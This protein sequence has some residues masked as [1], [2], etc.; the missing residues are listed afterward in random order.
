[1]I[2]YPN[3]LDN[4]VT[5][6]RI[7][8]NL[9]ELG[10]SAINQLREAVFS[11]EKTLGLNPQG[12]KSSVND[13]ISV[14]IGPD[15]NPKAE[16][17]QAIGLV[18]LPITNNQVANNA[19]IKEV[20]LDLNFSTASLHSNVVSLQS[21]VDIAQALLAEEN[22]NFLTHI[23][24]GLLLLDNL[25]SARHVASHI[26]IN[27]IPTDSRDTYTWDGLRD[28]DH[29]LRP[30]TQVAEALLEINNELVG[31]ENATIALVH[32]ATAISVDTS[33][34]TQL[35]AYLTN[36]QE[37]LGFVDNQETLSSGVDRSTMNANGIPRTARIQNL[38]R[39]GYTINVVPPT[40]I[41]AY[42]AEPSKIA[43]HDNINNGDDV[44]KFLPD[45]TN[46][47]FDSLF[48]NV[49][50]GDILRLN[51][52]NGIE[53]SY[54]IMSIRFLSGS[55]WSVRV[56]ANN[57]FDTGD[58]Y[59]GYARIDRPNFD[60]NTCGVLAAAGVVPSIYSSQ[61][62][63]D[64]IILGSP[65]GATAV[66]IGFD[67]GVINALHYNLYLRL[68][69]TGN[70]DV[71]YD[72]PAIDVSGNQGVTP[73]Y[74]NLDIVVENT[75][76][77][78]RLSGYNYRFIAFAHKG[79]FGIMLA[80]DYNGS[81]FSIISG[82]INYI[83][84]NIEQGSYVNNI[85]GDTTDQ[86]DALGLGFSRSGFATP[87]MSRLG[88]SEPYPTTIS[89]SN[90]S[91]LIITPVSGRNVIINGNR[92]DSLA[93][94]RFT[95]G[96]GYWSAIVTNITADI[97]HNTNFVTYSIPFDLATEDLAPGKTIVV[98][99]DTP[100]DTTI[101][102]YGRFIIDSV[103]FSCTGA[104]QTNITV[105]NSIHGTANPAQAPLPLQSRVRVY[106]SDDSVMF[107]IG[108]MVG[109]EL[110]DPTDYHHYH[111]VFVNDIGKSVAVERARMA[112]TDSGPVPGSGNIGSLSWRIRR[113]SPKLTGE[114]VGVTDFRNFIKL[115]IAGWNATTGEFNLYLVSL[116]GFT[117]GPAAKAK[118]NHVV[119]VYDKSGVNFIDIEFR[120]TYGN[121][122]TMP[123]GTV[124]IELF[125]TLK[126][127]DEYF[128]VAGVSHDGFVFKSITDL[129]DFGTISE[130]NLGDSAIKFIESG[131]R[132]L[133]ANGIIRGFKFISTENYRL[134]FK[135]GLALVNGSFVPMDATSVG[136]PTTNGE[137]FICVTDT[138]QLISIRKDNG[139][140][141]LNFIEAL[142]FKEIVDNRKDLTII[143]KATVSGGVVSP[144]DARR[145]VV[146]Q[147]LGINS[148]AYSDANS[149]SGYDDGN[150]SNV[151]FITPEALMNW[152]NEYHIKEVKV[153][154]VI[155][156]YGLTL[157][158]TSPVKLIGGSYVI[159]EARGLAFTSGNWT[160]DDADITYTPVHHLYADAND[161]FCTGGNWGGI[162][163]D[164]IP[165]SA[166]ISDFGIENSRFYSTS[167]QRAP[168][169]AIYSATGNSY[170]LF[171]NGRFVNNTFTD[172]QADRALC[173]AFV[174][175]NTPDVSMSSPYFQD[176]LVSDTKI[177]GR[178]GILI[179][180]RAT[181][182]VEYS[183]YTAMNKVLIENF[184]I[185][186]NRF[187]LIG[188]NV[189]NWIGSTEAGRFVIDNNKAELIY[190]GFS[191]TMNPFDNKY[192]YGVN[193]STGNTVSF[194]VRDNDCYYLKIEASAGANLLKSSV[195][196]NTIKRWDDV[197]YDAFVPDASEARRALVVFS[198]GLYPANITIANNTIDG[199]DGLTSGYIH[200]IY[201][202]GPGLSITG[203]I[204][205]NIAGVD[206]NSTPNGSGNGGW[207]IW[208]YGGESSTIVGNT[209][210]K[211]DGVGIA[212][213]IYSDA[214]AAIYGNTFSHFNL[215]SWSGSPDPDG[216]G[217][218]SNAN[219]NGI[220]GRGSK[221]AAWNV[222]QVVKTVPNMA[223]GIPLFHLDPG[224][225]TAITNTENNERLLYGSPA[226]S[227]NKGLKSVRFF[228][229]RGW[230]WEWNGGGLSTN[231]GTI[232]LILPLSSVIPDRA[233]LLSVEIHVY[234]SGPWDVL[235][236]DSDPI[237][238]FPQVSLELNGN[239]VDSKNP[240]TDPGGPFYTDV[241]LI[242][243]SDAL[244]TGF[245]GTRP[246]APLVKE[247]VVKMKQGL[248]GGTP[249]FGRWLGPTGSG[250]QTMRID[251]V[252]I[253]YLY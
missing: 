248:P 97:P 124:A 148:W 172:T 51:Y 143:Y 204:I 252:E 105:L 191:A 136:V 239:M 168:F 233:Y 231:D 209:I 82:Q 49:R 185:K 96:D 95:E 77:M 240:F 206:L 141:P 89:A 102:Y 194:V 37:A 238:V 58:G 2:R 78:L 115:R 66:G 242:Y 218:L 132:Y 52:G 151:N 6:V 195:T 17:L 109:A 207:G 253:M 202:Q 76:K 130:S 152:V 63:F 137:Y 106:F 184:V 103:S 145:F 144:S 81:S 25:T 30:A 71:F 129:R 154:D 227:I 175:S 39:D 125:P 55:D 72:L 178:Q 174:N 40:K 117:S 142:T 135:G 112:H 44:I 215:A 127:N 20:K 64:T 70:K 80:D 183:G 188:F 46:F 230:V 198:N 234:F 150:P 59:E 54:P 179:G 98:Q 92:R 164:G 18:T 216:Y 122:T 149:Q 41:H 23:S 246:P 133:H 176:I 163:I 165:L 50:V 69:P 167:A 214:T 131:E 91:T 113:V 244:I 65:R 223:S 90:Y 19:G 24:G 94:P 93:T 32:P 189:D 224:A 197:L 219:F 28:T 4:D 87:V 241:T 99:S 12:S 169:V 251:Q 187:G 250:T 229:D 14:L 126:N 212:G 38:Q 161:V 138:G 181:P 29:N 104:G 21:S 100:G 1:M 221:F 107:N 121:A 83:T 147:D 15:G 173:Y 8:D 196:G 120:E 5:I 16:A 134:S 116:D 43:P 128:A 74:Y 73:G 232:G 36:V 60:I 26:D 140:N 192:A 228:E 153:K 34:F 201:T 243:R 35:P 159:Y 13:R 235:P 190:S 9:S 156:N 193:F 48:T 170:N 47:V 45:N 200:G 33:T 139:S 62:F 162:V 237:N 119:R 247:M 42:L 213:Y 123:M 114:R 111:E 211:Q 160:I 53:T 84:G 205:N 220:Y 118:K 85:I 101:N 68:Y 155:L 57:M 75:N 7:D 186:N 182:A 171:H 56:N 203:N 67:P 166:T 79:E 157:N 177:N 22:A 208:S 61:S 210:S 31:H 110:S 3:S 86:Y 249:V 236:K 180:G 108:N 158:F 27:A 199:F 88:V 222:N 10:S 11:I 146:N 245:A 226:T 225:G 217:E